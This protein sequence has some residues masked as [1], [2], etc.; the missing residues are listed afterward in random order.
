M[1]AA[2]IALLVL[3]PQPDVI[4]RIMAVVGPQPITLSEVAAAAEFEL[5]P[6]PPGTKDQIGYALERLIDR[7]LILVEVERFQPPEPDPVEI[8]IQID[9]LQARFGSAEAFEKAL[10][11][12]GTTREQLRRYI[13]DTL[14]TQIYLNQRFGA[15][16]DPVERAESI[17]AWVRE[18]R[19]RTQITVLYRPA[20][21]KS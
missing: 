3:S 10:A 20:P 12:T 13:R 21:P 4:D 18:L 8:T 16:L 2:L 14:R 5:V 17:A 7:S 1:I 15:I 19:R 11:M 9:R 6:V